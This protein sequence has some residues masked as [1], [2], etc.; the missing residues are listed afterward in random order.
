M[1][2]LEFDYRTKAIFASGLED[3]IDLASK[4]LCANFSSKLPPLT[5]HRRGK[6]YLRLLTLLSQSRLQFLG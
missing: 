2:E 6:Y 5:Q 3:F 4:G 1:D